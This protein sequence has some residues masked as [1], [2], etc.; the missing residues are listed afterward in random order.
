M[1]PS[2]G[3]GARPL[4]T[5]QA[6]PAYLQGL[7]PI[8]GLI[9]AHMPIFA[10]G[11]QLLSIRTPGQAKD[12]VLVAPQPQPLG[13]GLKVPDANS[14]VVRGGGQH[15]SCPRVEAQGVDLLRVPCEH[16]LGRGKHLFQ[17]LRGHPPQSDPGVLGSH[18]QAVRVKRVPGQIG[19]SRPVL[20]RG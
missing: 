15:I 17:A 18:G 6:T 16:S 10:D 7:R 19:Y 2:W 3:L 20:Q 13:S 14:E 12:L 4:A 8:P 5:P 1:Q 9:D 11:G